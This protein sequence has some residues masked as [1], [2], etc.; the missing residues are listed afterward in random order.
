MAHFLIDKRP[1]EV[2]R[3]DVDFSELLLDTDT[4]LDTAKTK[5]AL[6]VFNSGGEDKTHFIIQDVL[7]DSKL[8]TL[9][10]QNG[11]NGED[12]NIYVKG[13]G[14][15]SYNTNQPVRVIELRSRLT[16]CGNV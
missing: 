12:Y 9:V 11:L 13:I 16:L 7:F 8:L 1:D 4:Q 14:D 3:Y 5:A 10:I 2:I 15:V 6:K